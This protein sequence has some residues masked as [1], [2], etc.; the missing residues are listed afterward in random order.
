M[1]DYINKVHNYNEQYWFPKIPM[2][3]FSETL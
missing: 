1:V 2:P 3:I